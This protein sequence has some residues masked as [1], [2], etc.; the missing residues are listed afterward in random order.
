MS[1]IKKIIFLVI[2]FISVPI[3][4]FLVTQKTNWFNKASD[5][6]AN[7][8]IDAGNMIGGK[9]ESWRNLAQGGEERGRQLL[10]VIDKIKAL[11]PKYIRIDHV[12][13]YYGEAELDQVIQDIVATGA[14]PF[15]A[16]SYMPPSLSKSGDVTDLPNDWGKW[17][18]LVQKTVEH[19]SGRNGL[20][21]KDVYYEVWNEPDLFGKFKTYG[22]K[23]YLELYSHTVRPAMR[24]NNVNS[25]KIGGPATTGF[26][27]NWANKLIMFALENRL[28][29]DFVSWHRYSKNLQDYEDDYNKTLNFGNLET[30]ISETGPNSENDPV[31]DGS[32]S[33]L[34]MIATTALMEGKVSKLFNF[35]IKDG[36]G[37]TKNWGRWGM[38]THEKWGTP[39]IKP[40]YR[41]MQ[42]LNNLIGG[43]NLQLDGQGSWVKAIAKRN[44]QKIQ[45][46]IVNYDNY[47]KHSETVPLKVTNLPTNSFVLKRIDFS[48]NTTSSPVTVENNSWETLLS[49]DPNTSS[50]LELTF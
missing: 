16:L 37:P 28:R 18:N 50:I 32:F 4:I 15:I 27:E 29:I 35:E 40:R 6:P 49:F 2:I 46:L 44:N 17:E 7:L 25:F 39:E 1:N 13:D 38:L 45:I 36:A 12:F 20:N 9:S 33:A 31:Y 8:I 11:K 10:P 43:S 5:L 34:H 47:G 48:G 41:A 19:V 23:N 22:P 3:S 24:A 26:Y 30:I 21:I 42:F 14:K